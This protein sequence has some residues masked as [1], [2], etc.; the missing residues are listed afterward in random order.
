MSMNAK[1]ASLSVAALLAIAGG[2][3]AFMPGNSQD[4]PAHVAAADPGQDV[5]AQE[6][7]NP[8]LPSTKAS[9]E[10]ADADRARGTA[11]EPQPGQ[12]QPVAAGPK[13]LTQQQLTPPPLTQDEK[14]QKA[15]EQESNF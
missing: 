1:T 11:A 15:A 8:Q 13:K 10:T 9:G 14:L 7:A 6:P 4:V 5:A 12:A 2:V 3:Y